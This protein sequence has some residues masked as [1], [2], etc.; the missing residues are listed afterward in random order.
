[1]HRNHRLVSV[2][3]GDFLTPFRHDS[4]WPEDYQ[5]LFRKAVYSHFERSA[6]DYPIVTLRKLLD[7]K[8]SKGEDWKDLREI[9]NII[10]HDNCEIEVKGKKHNLERNLLCIANEALNLDHGLE[11]PTTVRL[12]PSDPADKA[13]ME[14][15]RESVRQEFLDHLERASE[16]IK[17]ALDNRR[18]NGKGRITDR[19]L[20]LNENAAIL[21][22]I[23]TVIPNIPF[24]D[25]S[26]VHITVHETVVC[27]YEFLPD[28]PIGWV[29]VAGDRTK[30][31]FANDPMSS[32]GSFLRINPRLETDR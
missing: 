8:R 29:L 27:S 14:E 4:K 32:P 13:T 21:S 16:S 2:I 10:D 25:G 17:D 9:C 28:H 15:T 26:T 23:P 18:V 5:R 24:T 3:T 22:P 31:K 20:N 7:L 30:D 12:E 6:L 19:P 11:L 1:M